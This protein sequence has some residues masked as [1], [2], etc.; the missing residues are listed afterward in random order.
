MIDF[1]FWTKQIKFSIEVFSDLERQ[2]K[3]WILGD[4]SANTLGWYE[5]ICNLYDTNLFPE[6]LLE[7][8]QKLPINLFDSLDKLR[9][10]LDVYEGQETDL[11]VLKDPEWLT[12]VELSKRT[13]EIW[14]TEIDLKSNLK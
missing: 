10:K 9:A 8:K 2:K 1:D 4:K 7:H 3:G 12:I 6:Y 13:I 14:N 5:E 11:E